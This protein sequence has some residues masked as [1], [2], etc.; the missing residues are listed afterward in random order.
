MTERTWGGMGRRLAARLPAPRG[1]ALLVAG[2]A[3]RTVVTGRGPGPMIVLLQRVDAALERSDGDAARA[4][5]EPALIADPWR[6][7]LL[8]R[9]AA[10]SR[11]RGD[12]PTLLRPLSRLRQLGDDAAA[13]ELRR[14]AGVLVATE[15]GWVPRIAPPSAA[16]EASTPGPVVRVLL[17]EPGR[18]L[19]VAATRALAG[20]AMASGGGALGIA[21]PMGAPHATPANEHVTVE[22]AGIGYPADAPL[23][24]AI[25]DQAWLAVRALARVRPA[26]VIVDG[27]WYAGIVAAAVHEALGVPVVVGRCAAP[28]TGMLGEDRARAARDRWLALLDATEPVLRDERVGGIAAA[29]RIDRETQPA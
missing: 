23:P 6:R 10:L 4:I 9:D 15:P 11:L 22:R 28:R 3:L 20:W 21:V 16:T 18:T 5:L 24:D 7:E 12:A 17:A 26:L 19:P 2:R 27:P 1:A 25:R 13:A 14:V 29:A 8:L